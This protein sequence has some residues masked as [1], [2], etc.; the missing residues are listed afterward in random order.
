MNKI[1]NSCIV[2]FDRVN[3]HENVESIALWLEPFEEERR[4]FAEPLDAPNSLR[5]FDA[6]HLITEGTATA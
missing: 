4:T 5:K 2:S 3:H 6:H 1:N